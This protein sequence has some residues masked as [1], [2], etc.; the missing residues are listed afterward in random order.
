MPGGEK[1]LMDTLT[2][3]DLRRL[4]QKAVTLRARN[5][6]LISGL[7]RENREFQSEDLVAHHHAN[8]LRSR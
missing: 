1:G 5:A 6:A 3:N 8:S 4:M 2:L 7:N